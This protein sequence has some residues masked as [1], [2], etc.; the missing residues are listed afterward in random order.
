MFAA[1]S[2]LLLSL[3]NIHIHIQHR[4]R[5]FNVIA[6][7]TMLDTFEILTT[8]GV[9]LWS[10]SYTTISAS[11]INNFIANVFIEERSQT[12]GAGA[13][14]DA[15]AADNPPYKFEQHTIR[16]TMVKEL[17]I[18]FVVGSQKLGLRQMLK[19]WIGCLPIIVTSFLD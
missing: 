10:R 13:T 7:I 19:V 5:K 8:S 1:A 2:A 17:N 3:A 18:I 4:H 14:E 9:V 16:W 15:S 12:T 11:I 6:L